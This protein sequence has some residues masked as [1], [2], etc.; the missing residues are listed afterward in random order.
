MFREGFGCPM[1]PRPSYE[2]PKEVLKPKTKAPS[3]IFFGERPDNVR[4][5]PI[6][7]G[8]IHTGQT[9]SLF[10]PPKTNKSTMAVDMTVH[11]AAGKDWRGMRVK[12]P[13]AG[14][15]LA[16]ERSIQVLD[17]LDAYETKGFEDLPIAVMPRLID[18]VDP[19]CVDEIAA[20]IEATEKRF[21]MQ[22]GP[23]TF[24]TWNKG[25]A[26]GGGNEDKAEHQNAAAANLR[27][28]IERFPYVHCM[29][30]GHTGKDAERGE[31]G[32]NATQGDRDVG[33]VI[34]RAY[35]LRVV[36]VEYANSIPDQRNIT[37]FKVEPM[38]IG[39]DD[40]ND[41]IKGLTVSEKLWAIPAEKG[42]G[43]K[44]IKLP[45]KAQ[46]AL[47]A[48]ETALARHGTVRTEAGDGA[49]SVTDT[50]WLEVCHENG[51]IGDD[52][53]RPRRDLSEHRAK[54][55]AAEIAGY[56]AP[57]IWLT[58]DVLPPIPEREE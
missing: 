54:L 10:G 51:T 42:K 6:I 14:L 15:Y 7:K 8:L 23:I 52:A 47:K 11:I 46:L 12:K 57:H 37:A 13:W 28:I 5:Q 49:K 55:V 16:F 1:A 27:R 32:S 50:E 53:A 43:D 19:H 34:R 31:R 29:T 33:I 48:L 24:D 41:P 9:S 25:I 39:I 18:V 56:A 26:A 44:P 45:A 30:I 40:D 17:S 36:R 58:G 22:V 35:D 3:L 20:A 38:A 2:I 4:S 21:G